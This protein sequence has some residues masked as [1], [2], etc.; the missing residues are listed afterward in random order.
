MADALAAELVAGLNHSFIGGEHE[1]GLA[2]GLAHGIQRVEN[3]VGG[4]A[5]TVE[6]RDE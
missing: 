2:S 1:R 4:L 6:R 3:R 5:R